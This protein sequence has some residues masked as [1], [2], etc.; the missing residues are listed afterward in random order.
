MLD[1]PLDERVQILVFNNLS[2]LKQSNVN[3][4]SEEDYNTGGVTRLSGRRLFLYFDGD[5]NQMENHLRAG[6]TEVVLSNM[7][8][9]QFYRVHPKLG[10]AQ[11]ARVVYG[12]ADF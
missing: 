5:F 7:I 12:R 4:S 8:Y 10:F 9:W 11:L 1:A 6:L 3:S 2:D